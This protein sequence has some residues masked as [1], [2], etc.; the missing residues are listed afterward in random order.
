MVLCSGNSN[1]KCRGA[2][3]ALSPAP[4]DAVNVTDADLWKWMN[5]SRSGAAA[6]M[7]GLLA[8]SLPGEP[9]TVD[10]LAYCMKS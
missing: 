10:S 5:N 1:V 8:E 4:A 3:P 9:A 7:L 2:D 6:V